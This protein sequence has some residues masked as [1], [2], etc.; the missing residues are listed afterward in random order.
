MATLQWEAI[1]QK[2]QL[3]GAVTY[4]LESKGS[5]ALQLQQKR[6]PPLLMAELEQAANHISVSSWRSLMY[7][8]ATIVLADAA[9][10]LLIIVLAKNNTVE[11]STF[12][13]VDDI[14]TLT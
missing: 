5:I 9:S 4:I 8:A 11:G 1:R 3:E 7:S 12:N 14:R 13:S 10:K 2:K 6:G